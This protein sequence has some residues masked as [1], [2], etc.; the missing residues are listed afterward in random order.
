MLNYDGT[1]SVY[2]TQVQDG[3]E[4]VA[5]GDSAQADQK[6]LTEQASSGPMYRGVP[7]PQ[8]LICPLDG[9]MFRSAVI[10]PCCGRSYSASCIADLI[11]DNDNATCPGC[12]SDE[13][14]SANLIPNQQ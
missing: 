4:D 6:A 8:E 9:R 10:V 14:S 12:G 3:S 2:K 13:L 5:E 7:I 11:D 1:W